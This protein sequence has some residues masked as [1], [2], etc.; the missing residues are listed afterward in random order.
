[1]MQ[2]AAYLAFEPGQIH[3]M[4]PE[5]AEVLSVMCRDLIARVYVRQDPTRPL[6]ERRFVILKTDEACPDA[7]TGRYIGTMID[8]HRGST[9][10]WHFF[11]MIEP[12]IR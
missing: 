10:D 3:W 4:M 9:P 7:E 11:E 1:M 2:I 5:G 8:V 12:V 6:V